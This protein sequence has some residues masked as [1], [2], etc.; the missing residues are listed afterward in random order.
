MHFVNIKSKIVKIIFKRLPLAGIGTYIL[1]LRTAG[2]N[3]RGR[4]GKFP[5]SDGHISRQDLTSPTMG[6]Y[7]PLGAGLQEQAPKHLKLRWLR[8]RV[9]SVMEACQDRGVE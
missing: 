4:I 8:A 2:S 5:T 7:R 9:V 1:A 3:T 6:G